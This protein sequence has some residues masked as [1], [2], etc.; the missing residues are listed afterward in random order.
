MPTW[1]IAYAD[2][3]KARDRFRPHLQKTS[4]SIPKSC[5]WYRTTSSREKECQGSDFP[6][7]EKNRSQLSIQGNP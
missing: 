6:C 3:L 7:R 5:R 4:R 1:P 2:V